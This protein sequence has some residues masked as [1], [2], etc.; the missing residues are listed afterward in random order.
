MVINYVTD[1][2]DSVLTTLR[3]SAYIQFFSCFRVSPIRRG[4]TK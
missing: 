2:T 3:I 4:G 1:A